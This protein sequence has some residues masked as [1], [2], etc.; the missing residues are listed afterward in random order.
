MRLVFAIAFLLGLAVCRAGP[1]D[2]DFYVSPAGS[3]LE[4]GRISAPFA[5]LARARD[6]VREVAKIKAG[7]I[8]V[9]V[10][11]GRY[12]LADTLVFGP[13]DSGV[14]DS[15]I[16]YAAFPGE[17]PVFSA[18]REVSGW[19][20]VDSDLPGL[21]RQARGKLW[22]ADVSRRFYSLYDAEGLL[23]RARSAGFIPH[24]GG[25]HHSLKFP[26]G[27]LKAWPNLED[28]EIVIRPHHAWVLN[29][30]PL[31]S[32]DEGAGIARTSIPATYMMNELHYLNG[33]DSCWVENVLEALDEPG[34]WVLNTQ[35]GKLYLWPRN[36]S[37]PTQ[38]IAPL[39]QEAIRVEGRIDKKGPTD[40]PVRN[41][42]IRGLTLTH[43]ARVTWTATDKGLQHDWA[44]HDKGNALI[45]FR[46]TENC[47]IQAC[48]FVHSAGTAIR[49]DLYGQ[50]NRVVGN[51]I[52]HVGGV[53]VLLCGYGPGTKDVN[54]HNMIA[55]NHVHHVGEI[56]SHSPGMFLWQSGQ[57][58]VANNL[59]HHTPY[60]GLVISG[61]MSHM[62]G[63]RDNREMVRTIRWHEIPGKPK[64]RKPDQVQRFLHSHDNIVEYNE[65]HHVMELMGDG[66]G[67]YIR[68]AGPGN[69]IRR[70]YIHHMLAPLVMQSAIR[71]DGG[72]AI[73]SLQRI[74]STSA[75]VTAYT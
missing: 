59:I 34:E 25:K 21:P 73:R 33:T 62:F 38:V 19:K 63:R 8:R 30:L 70:N 15:L 4:S 57:N 10:R 47:E 17:T 69:V 16:T 64:A 1:K 65:I 37:V 68:G 9:L 27:R 35:E 14:G 56:Y 18:G 43:G 66:N 71:T 5:T 26:K 42:R 67:I 74:S 58:H 31:Q 54:H 44:M 46:G 39:L 48:H 40:I 3:D 24:E 36:N 61:V 11:G 52:E 45:R 22:V 6:A 55:N 50:Q 60:S 51:H 13:E 53:G 41:L 49:V 20:Q 12:E 32:V 75:S 72:S 28:V 29:I 2:G 23:P 7:D